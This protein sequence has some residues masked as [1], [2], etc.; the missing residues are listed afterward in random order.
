MNPQTGMLVIPDDNDKMTMPDDGLHAFVCPHCGNNVFEGK[1]IVSYD[2]YEGQ[3][4]YR[5]WG[6]F[7]YITYKWIPHKCTACNAKFLAWK[8]NRSINGS[9]IGCY[10]GLII[11]LITMFVLTGFAI[12]LN[13][14]FWLADIPGLIVLM[15]CIG[16]I[17]G[18][19]CDADTGLE[20]IAKVANFPNDDDEDKDEEESMDDMIRRIQNEN[21]LRRINSIND[22]ATQNM[23]SP[24]P[25]SYNPEPSSPA[26][27]ALDILRRNPK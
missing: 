6:G 15:I 2:D 11:T 21:L 3:R 1:D 5:C 19:T 7:G 17:E 9:V 23:S 22:I 14:S 25:F 13:K 8:A 24:R 26:A 4:T 16:N 27:M 12:S 10:I 20:D 18:E